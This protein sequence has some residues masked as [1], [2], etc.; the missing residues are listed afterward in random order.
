MCIRDRCSI[1][2]NPEDGTFGETIDTLVNAAAMTKSISFPRD[3]YKR[4]D[5]NRYVCSTYI[6]AYHPFLIYMDELPDWDVKDRLTA[7]AC[8]VSSR[9]HWVRGFHTWMLGLA[10]QWMGAVSY[11]HLDVYKRQ[12]NRWF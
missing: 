7:L 1:D 3:V 2:F 8:R 9:P 5:L 12:Y 4:Q 10:S 11:T 6:P